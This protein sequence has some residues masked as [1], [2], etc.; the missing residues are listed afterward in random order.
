MRKRQSVFIVERRRRILHDMF[1]HYRHSWEAKH[2]KADMERLLADLPR[3]VVLFWMRSGVHLPLWLC[4]SA[5]RRVRHAG[6]GR[7][8]RPAEGGTETRFFRGTPRRKPTRRWK[9]RSV[10][11]ERPIHDG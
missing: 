11:V 5:R 2:E 9:S 10:Y 6:H 1:L 4:R 7:P 8:T 3:I